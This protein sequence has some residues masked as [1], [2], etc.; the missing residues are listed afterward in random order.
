MKKLL[1]LFLIA[2][3]A[4]FIACGGG[5]KAKEKAKQDSLRKDSISKVRKADSLAAIEKANQKTDSLRKDSIAKAEKAKG[6][7]AKPKP[8]HP[9]HK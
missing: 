9:V 1:A 2:G 3:I 6:H 7:H 5:D 8:K 4:A